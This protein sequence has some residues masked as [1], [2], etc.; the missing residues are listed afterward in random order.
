MKN[1]NKIDLLKGR[2]KEW[3]YYNRPS[4]NSSFQIAVISIVILIML[5]I[6]MGV[7]ELVEKVSAK[8]NDFGDTYIQYKDDNIGGTFIERE[9][10]LDGLYVLPNLYYDERTYITSP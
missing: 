7:L 6:G 3:D 5:I 9:I 1:K 4:I 10:Q 2:T 8:E